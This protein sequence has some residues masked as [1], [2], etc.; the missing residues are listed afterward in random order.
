MPLFWPMPTTSRWRPGI[1]ALNTLGAPAPAKSQVLN[2]LAGPE[3]VAAAAHQVTL[4]GWLP[5][6][7]SHASRARAAERPLRLAGSDVERDDRIGID[8][9]RKTRF[10]PAARRRREAGGD[11]GRLPVEL[12]R[13]RIH[14]SFFS[15]S[16]TG[17]FTNAAPAKPPGWPPLSGSMWRC[18]MMRP[19][20]ASTAS[21]LP[22][23]VQQPGGRAGSRSTRC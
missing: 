12:T 13:G 10:I 8:A 3:A 23:N 18:Q 9:R 2:R 16:M 20:S 21:R 19:V 4:A 6:A 17:G 11:A 1:F 5:H 15:W 7:S 22:R 14:Q